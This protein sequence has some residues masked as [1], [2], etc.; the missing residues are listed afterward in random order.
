V[1]SWRC[2]CIPVYRDATYSS[3]M[4]YLPW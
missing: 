2:I 3:T 1:G 4:L